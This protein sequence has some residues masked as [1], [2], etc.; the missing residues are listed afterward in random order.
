MA[1]KTPAGKYQGFVATKYDEYG[2]PISSVVMTPM[3]ERRDFS[4]EHLPVDDDE[5]CAMF[6]RRNNK[7]CNTTVKLPDAVTEDSAE[8]C[9]DCFAEHGKWPDRCNLKCW[10]CLYTFDTRPFPCPIT[11]YN[12]EQGHPT[13]RV[14]GVFC[15]PSC[16]KAWATINMYKPNFHII[17][18]L[19]FS[20]GF[21]SPD[22]KRMYI[23]KAPPRECLQDFSGVL[24]MTIEQFRGLCAKGID[25][26]LHAPP[27]ITQM[28]VITAES[29]NLKQWGND[30][31]RPMHYETP[32]ELM[33]SGLELAKRKREG[34][35]I[36]A[37]IGAKRL[38]DFFP[39]AAKKS[40][41]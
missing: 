26:N 40:K 21:R 19:A 15:G 33:V 38:T 12:D 9:A 2:L 14:R 16:A 1:F 11:S 18:E 20:R 27:F 17:D 36:F 10:W 34:F 29:R 5:F 4:D 37:G 32:A 3:D 31:N 6:R 8:I 13:Y 39:P 24:G 35:E 41:S 25:V 23:P 28:Q 22:G 7:C 30:K